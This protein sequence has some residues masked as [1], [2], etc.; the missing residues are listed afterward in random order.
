MSLIGLL[1]GQFESPQG[2]S[3]SFSIAPL[4][5]YM[6]VP[7]YIAD[8]LDCMFYVHELKIKLLKSKF[9][10]YPVSSCNRS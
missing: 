3:E 2:F 1:R 5:F 6:L 10:S 4:P 8:L 7:T 9:E